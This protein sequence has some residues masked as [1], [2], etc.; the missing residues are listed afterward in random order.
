MI[1]LTEAKYVDGNR[2]WIKFTDGSSGIVDFTDIIEK[3]PTARPLA[4]PLEFQRFYLD[5]WPTLAWPCG[6]DFSPEGLYERATGRRAVWANTDTKE[7][8]ASL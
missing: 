5:E 6:F 8:T 7:E 2:I 4:D 1:A 3:Y